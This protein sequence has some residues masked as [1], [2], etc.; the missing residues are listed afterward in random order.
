MKQNLDEAIKVAKRLKTCLDAAHEESI[1]SKNQFAE[2]V[3]A[4]LVRQ[5]DELWVK[6]RA[7]SA[8]ADSTHIN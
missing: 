1:F 6:I 3:L 7:V 2:I 4:D 8:A 5:A